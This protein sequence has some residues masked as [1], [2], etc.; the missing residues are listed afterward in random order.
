MSSG[1]RRA[2]GSRVA[3]L[4][5]GLAAGGGIC[6]VASMLIAF[7]VADHS[8]SDSSPGSLVAIGLGSIGVI[9]VILGAAVRAAVSFA[10][11]WHR[12]RR[13]PHGGVSGKQL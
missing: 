10:W 3:R 6:I 4:G 8:S 1:I 2:G 9:L 13:P 7:V 12:V 5:T 11:L